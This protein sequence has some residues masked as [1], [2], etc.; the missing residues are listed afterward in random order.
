M[1]D[2]YHTD[3]AAW[4]KTQADALRRNSSNELDWSNI[5]EEIESLGIAQ[6]HA[7]D[8]RLMR[9]C[10]H[11]LKLTYLPDPDPRRLWRVS[12]IEQRRSIIR[13][14]AKSPSLHG[15]PASVLADCYDDARAIVMEYT[16]HLPESCPW[17][18]EQVLDKEFYPEA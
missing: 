11:L 10:E 3:I 7:L 1:T 5:A 4:S 18:I 16:E 13:L 9:I 6:Q 14:L 15:Y 12:I 17:T 2:D 8:S